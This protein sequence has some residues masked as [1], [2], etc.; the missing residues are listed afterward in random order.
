M[1]CTRITNVPCTRLNSNKSI[2]QTP[3]ASSIADVPYLPLAADEKDENSNSSVVTISSDVT[4][5]IPPPVDVSFTGPKDSLSSL[6]AK[7]LSKS[8]SSPAYASVNSSEGPMTPG[9]GEIIPPAGTI[10]SSL[11]EPA[12]WKKWLGNRFFYQVGLIYMCTRLV[13]NVS[14]TLLSFYLLDALLLPQSSIT[15]VP[16]VL[17]VAQLAATVCMKRINNYFGRKLAYTVGAAFIA[18]ASVAMLF[19]KSSFPYLIFPAIVSLGIGCAITTVIS[20]QMQADMLG[21]N[22]ASAAFVYGCH[23]FTDKLSNGVAIF[24]VQQINGDSMIHVRASI[25]WVPL[26]AVMASVVLTYMLDFE[27]MRAANAVDQEGRHESVDESQ[28]SSHA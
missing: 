4:P 5:S 21:V 26:V 2:N 23:S 12:Q 9:S 28:L 13:M 27:T 17:Y 3:E 14:Q 7:L 16:L 8:T 15:I 18:V 11:L 10:P 6:K 25:V 22:T 19:L 1:P 20:V 24:V